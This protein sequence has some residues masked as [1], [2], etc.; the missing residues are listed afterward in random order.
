LTNIARVTPNELWR[1]ALQHLKQLRT[2]YGF[3]ASDVETGLYAA[4]F[5]RDSLWIVIF[6]LEAVSRTNLPRFRAWVEHA[7]VDAFRALA[8]HQGT[9]LCD[10]IEEQPG[11]IVHEFRDEIDDRLRRMGLNFRNGR[12]YSGFDQTFLF[13]I[14]YRLFADRHPNHPVSG[15]LWPAVESALRWMDL[16][17]DDDGDALFEYRRRD[18]RN[19]LH[20]VWR[21]SFDSIIETGVDAPPHPIA[22]LSVQAY[23]Y[24]ALTDAAELYRRAEDRV[25]AARFAK[26]AAILRQKVNR[27]FWLENEN[28]LAIAVD[29]RKAPVTMVSSDAGHALWSGIVDSSLEPAL[30]RRLMQPDLMTSYGLRTLSS[31]SPFYAPFSYHRGNIWPF[32]NAVFL[33]GLLDH[34]Y[35]E[36]ARHVIEAV[37]ST[38]MRMGSPLELYIALDRELFVEPSL[39]VSYALLKRRLAQENK[40]QGFSAAALVLMAAALA[41]FEGDEIDDEHW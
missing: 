15:E 10:E 17:A 6:L 37:S 39:A 36:E 18:E 22:W 29:A 5:G 34:G 4:L 38:V 40:N 33:L 35:R 14:A 32:D 28:C 31:E 11:K 25:T 23:S 8:I 1:F 41:G 9:C 21:D 7:A 24:R 3:A 13:V 19:L 16:W 12:S 27:S 26:R 20:Q 2:D 30:V